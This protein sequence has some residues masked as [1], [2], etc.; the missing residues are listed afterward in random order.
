[1]SAYTDDDLLALSGIQHFAF[2]PRQWALI[3]LERQWDE[4]LR[5]MEGKVL[6]ERVHDSDFFEARGDV[7]TA[8]SVP[9]HPVRVRGL[10]QRRHLIGHGLRKSHPMR[11]RG[12]KRERRIVVDT[13]FLVAPHAG[14]RIETKFKNK[15]YFCVI[16][17]HPMRVRG[18]KLMS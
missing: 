2:C 11:V 18:L 17:S 12:L 9:S 8:R 5:T 6:H 16:S 13:E 15:K 7:L 3:H 14:A 4:N 10:K 1:M